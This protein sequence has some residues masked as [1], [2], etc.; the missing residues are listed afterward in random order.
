[1]LPLLCHLKNESSYWRLCCTFTPMLHK[2]ARVCLV[3]S[4]PALHKLRVLGWPE[5][6][7]HNQE[8]L[9]RAAPQLRIIT[10]KVGNDSESLEAAQAKED[11]GLRVLTGTFCM[12]PKA[13]KICQ[14]LK[15]VSWQ[16]KWG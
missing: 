7:P 3:Q 10:I 12:P 1:M 16:D 2:L 15:H 5:L 13:C 9:R 8:T 14:G 11:A 4:I 6:G